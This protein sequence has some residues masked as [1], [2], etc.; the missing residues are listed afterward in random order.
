[1]TTS[2][3]RQRL[4]G[5]LATVA[6]L[7]IIIGLPALFLAIGANPISDQAPTLQSVKD[8][9]LAPDDGTLILGL[10]K[11]IGWAAWAFMTLSLVVET[12]A[13]LRRVEAPKL[14]GLG[15]PQAAAHGLIGLAALLFIAAPIA[16]QAANAGPAAVRRHQGVPPFRETQDYVDRVLI[17]YVA[18][19][20][21]F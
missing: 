18:Y 17:Y 4:T 9:L 16:A 14:P 20:D 11:V 8:A 15:R 19:G 6:V 10:F 3:L 1:M 7:G 13:R 12:I 5:L 2:T 21:A